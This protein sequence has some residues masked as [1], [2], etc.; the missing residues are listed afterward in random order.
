MKDT[1][2]SNWEGPLDN[3]ANI[4]FTNWLTELYNN[5]E[6]LTEIELINKSKKLKFIWCEPSCL[7]ID[8]DKNCDYK[9]VTHDKSFSIEFTDNDNVV[10]WVNKSFGFKLYKRKQG[11]NN[12][13]LDIDM[14]TI[15]W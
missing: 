13:I 6:A 3:E 9:I 10:F 5:P 1:P 8:L 14:S 2:T 12:W 7:G 15:N 4:I 11:E